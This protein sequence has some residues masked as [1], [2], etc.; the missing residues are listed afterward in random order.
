MDYKNKFLAGGIRIISGFVLV[1]FL[2]SSGLTAQDPKEDELLFMAKK[3]Y[4]DGFYEVSLGI[5]ERFQ[6]NYR[7]SDKIPQAI[8]LSGQCYFYQG[9]Y[10][11]ALSIFE[12]LLDNPR[13]AGLI[14][15]LYFWMGEIHF[16]GNNLDKAA[17][18][19]QKLIDNFPQSSFEP[20]A[21]YSL[22]WSFA[23][24]GKFKQAIAVFQ[25]LIGKFP[26]EPQSKDAAFKLIECLYNL[27][28]YSELKVRI[29]P[30]FKLYQNDLVRLPYLYFY[31]AEA[32]Y[33]LDNLDAAAKNYLKSAQG[34]KDPKAQ[35]LAKLG[36]GWSYLK[37]ARY[38][39]TEDVFAQINPESL[40]KKSLD[41]FLLGQA[42]LNSATN[43]VYEA[44][45]LYEQIIGLSN[46]PVISLQAY[47][48]K[49]DA[50]YNLA[51][52]SL[53][54]EVYKQGLDKIDREDL[55]AILPSELVDKLW[56]NLGMAYLK[57]G[58]FGLSLEVFNGIDEKD[59]EQAKAKSDLIFQIAQGYDQ[60]GDFVKAE[61][62]YGRMIQL[63]PDSPYL[64]YVQYQA[65]STQYK[66][67][68]Y[69]KAIAD[70][71]VWLKKY[72]QSKL[73]PEAFYLM[74]TAYF[75]LADYG[76]SREIFTKFAEGFKDS[77]LRAQALYMLGLS[78]IN[79]GETNEALNVFR[80]I[81][82]TDSLDAEL[83]QRVE[84]E[85]ADCYFKLGQEG[86]AAEKFKILRSKYP[87]SKLTANVMWWLGQYYYR[88][89]DLNLARRYF[90]AL[91]Q[92]YPDSQLAAQAFYALGLTFSDED[93]FEPAI[94]NFKAAF[95][96]A[97]LD[98]KAQA[99]VAL[100]DI[101]NRQERPQEALEQY[102]QAI[103]NAPALSKSLFPRIAQ[104][105]Y[106]AG[107]YKEAEKFYFKSLEVTVEPAQIAQ[108]R[109]SLAEVLE[110]DA[111]PDAAIQQY[112]LAADL[113]AGEAQF[114]VRSLLRVA[115]LY[116]DKENLKEALKI[117]NRIIQQEPEA[118]E[119]GFIRERIS[120]L[121]E[122]MKT[123]DRRR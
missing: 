67:G 61:E 80:G 27:K 113:Y 102:H 81:L 45:K 36:L 3:A 99:A 53:A 120:W 52:Y 65:A 106:K 14:D 30:A 28:E 89:K 64:E 63:Y 6:K 107:N 48:G 43:R 62:L 24:M 37:L 121:Q 19:Y 111:R 13:A 35:V 16:K 95:K 18:F 59:R 2:V 56:Y 86:Q 73:L 119:A 31:L 94:D 54:V 57:Q 79:L 68:D 114:F 76:R 4:E 116:E 117:Y 39:D 60:A 32:E 33:Y 23:Q 98:L 40:D 112:L 55:A 22:G 17:M 110:S 46:D 122:N 72:P 78:L 84:Y 97:N 118:A 29:K 47:L 1:L 100:A 105:N 58:Q 101:Y 75:S 7:D 11:E 123:D 12:S 50:H 69:Q 8:L 88:N 74:G 92:D 20:A 83:S 25:A 34:F 70:L 15:A 77:R 82:K 104:A 49:A 90:S 5:L 108:L 109:F 41:V 44:R 103:K 42:L 93:K 21:Y 71:E 87:N 51:E 96:L 66:K 26:Q 38:K 115:K 91:T 85:I 10:L 9:R